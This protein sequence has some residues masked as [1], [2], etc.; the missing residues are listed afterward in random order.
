MGIAETGWLVNSND[1][2]GVVPADVMIALVAYAAAAEDL[3]GP[4]ARC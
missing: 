3:T 4:A 1:R 2:N